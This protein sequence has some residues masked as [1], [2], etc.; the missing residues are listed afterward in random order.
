[1]DT[2]RYTEWKPALPVKGEYEL[3][4]VFA[5][6]FVG[7]NPDDNGEV[8]VGTKFR[9]EILGPSD[10]LMTNGASAVGF[11]FSEL[12]L[13][14]KRSSS[15]KYVEMCSAKWNAQL[16]VCFGDEV[17]PTVEPEDFFDRVFIATVAPKWSEFDQAEVA[18]VGF[19]RRLS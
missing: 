16:D 12:M 6:N 11:Q 9:Y 19:R 3:K 8:S 4:I 13:E 18:T 2:S 15:P 17:P 10:R 5:E 1:M 14:P 7:K